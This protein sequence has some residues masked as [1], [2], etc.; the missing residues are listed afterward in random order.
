MVG[1]GSGMKLIPTFCFAYLGQD[2]MISGNLC[3]LVHPALWILVKAFLLCQWFTLTTD[4]VFDDS[5]ISER[6]TMK[7]PV[8]GQQK[9]IRQQIIDE[10]HEYEMTA[11]ELS[12]AVRIPEKEVVLH[13]SH[14][15][16]TVAAQGKRLIIQPFQCLSCGYTFKERKRFSRPGRCPKCKDTHVESP[17]FR[18]Q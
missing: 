4:V 17:T 16:K 14:I 1:L 8:E 11:R 9:T 12:Q 6:G 15:S 2:N 18:I 5:I 13:L 3:G 10:L 7:E